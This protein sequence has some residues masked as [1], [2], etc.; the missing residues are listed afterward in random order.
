MPEPTQHGYWESISEKGTEMF[1]KSLL[2]SFK[3]YAA[4]L[5][6]WIWVLFFDGVAAILGLYLD[7]TSAGPLANWIWWLAILTVA[8]LAP[9]VTFHRQRLK[10]AELQTQLSAQQDKKNALNRL[11]DLLRDGHDLDGQKLHSES[12]VK[13]WKQRL[14]SWIES[15]RLEIAA[16]R[17]TA[18]AQQFSVQAANWTGS[19]DHRAFDGLHNDGLVQLGCCLRWLNHFISQKSAS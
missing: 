14:D 16:T 6:G 7:I 15:V 19:S 4:E 5:G 13:E 18:E 10:A 8:L 12:E 3:A 11:G 17:S 1:S 9:F 2:A